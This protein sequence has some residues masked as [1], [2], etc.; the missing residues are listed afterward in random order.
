MLFNRVSALAGSRSGSRADVRD[1]GHGV[2]DRGHGG[3]AVGRAADVHPHRHVR[4]AVVAAAGHVGADDGVRPAPAQA[5]PDRRRARGAGLR[6]EPQRHRVDA[7]AL[8]LVVVAPISGAVIFSSVWVV[9]NAVCFWVVDGRSSPTRSPTAATP[10]PPTP[11]RSSGRGAAVLRLRRP[12]R[13]RRLLP[14]PRAAGPA[15]PA[16]A[17][18]LAGWT[19]PLVAL[20]RRP[21]S[22][23]L[24]WRPAVRHYR[25]DGLVMRGARPASASSSYAKAGG[26]GAT[27]AGVAAVDGVTSASRAGEAVGYIG[28]NGAGKSTTI[29]MLTGILVPTAGHVRVCGLDPVAQAARAGAA[30]RRGVRPAQP[31]V[32][33]PA[34]AGLL[35]A[36]R[37]IHRVPAAAYAARLRRVRRAA[38]HGPFLDT[39]V[40]QLSLGQRMR[41]EVTAAL[42]HAP[43]LLVLDE[44]TIG[45]DLVSKERLRAFLA[46]LNARARHDP[47]AHHARPARHRAALP[48]AA[49]DRPRPV[50]ADGPL[51]ALRAGSPP[52]GCSSSTSP[53]PARRWTACR[54]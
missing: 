22:A 7:G 36:A 32:V 3:G 24:V 17:A 9:A 54:A 43:E 12:R 49:G 29:K 34:A 1:R 47:A 13:L 44:P 25:G 2:R 38:G 4:R 35:R 6:L 14:E 53:N 10:S 33:G 42:L 11:S 39:P 15:R 40:R 16:R 51:A 21:W 8:A 45:L 5:R 52:S 41:G 28:P 46:E 37:R 23:G 19:S 20:W 30:D 48:P 27:A 31:A 18:G 50:L 26:S